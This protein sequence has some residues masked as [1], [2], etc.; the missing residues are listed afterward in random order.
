MAKSAMDQ[1]IEGIG[2]AV[3]DVREK[4]VEQAYFG[5]TVTDNI[6]PNAELSATEPTPTP[7]KEKWQELV[8]GGRE[9]NDRDD[10][11]REEPG[12]DR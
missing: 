2:N 12:L 3:H 11:A 4:A 8:K 6:Q 10:M 1:F 9:P 7:D 5:Q